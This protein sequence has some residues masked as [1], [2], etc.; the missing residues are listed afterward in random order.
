MSDESQLQVHTESALILSGARSN[1]I[2][3]GRRDATLLAPRCNKCGEAKELVFAGCVCAG[4]SEALDREWASSTASDWLVTRPWHDSRVADFVLLNTTYA[5]M[6]RYAWA[7]ND[8]ASRIKGFSRFREAA[9][10][11]ID[12]LKSASGTWSPFSGARVVRT[13]TPEEVAMKKRSDREWEIATET[14]RII[15]DTCEKLGI[16][17]QQYWVVVEGADKHDPRRAKAA[18]EVEGRLRQLG[19]LEELA[20]MKRENSGAFQT[21]DDARLL[22]MMFQGEVKAGPGSEVH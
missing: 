13:A 16:E 22:E 5:Q 7:A 17:A 2:A 15:Y 11:E 6:K 9:L 19:W 1:L 4:C 20:K 12:C 10:K 14:D 3:R 21:I 18:E 8:M